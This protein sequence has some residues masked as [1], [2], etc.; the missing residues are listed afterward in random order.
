M[1]EKQWRGFAGRIEPEVRLRDEPI[2]G[3]ILTTEH[4]PIAPDRERFVVLGF[5]RHEVTYHA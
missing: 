2:T 1:V 3:Q 4:D 5:D